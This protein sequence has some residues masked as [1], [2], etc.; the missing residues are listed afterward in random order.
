[1]EAGDR[2]K[3]DRRDALQV[4]EKFGIRAMMGN[5]RIRKRRILNRWCVATAIGES[6]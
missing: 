2:V 3:T 6:E 4:V 5:K 1:M